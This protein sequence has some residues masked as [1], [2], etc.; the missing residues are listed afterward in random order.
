M[1]FLP[2]ALVGFGLVAWQWLTSS[3]G[4]AESMVGAD[5]SGAFDSYP[6]GC[7]GD[8]AVKAVSVPNGSVYRVSAWPC[9]GTPYAHY[10]VAQ[11]HLSPCW[12]G[13]KVYG[14][15]KRKFWRGNG[16]A[17]QVNR[18]CVELGVTR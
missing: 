15:G 2:I 8:A 4:S 18:M 9:A 14:T 12:I 3:R 11:Q 5:V 1:P 17:Q 7:T 16:T 10:A 6:K 13:F